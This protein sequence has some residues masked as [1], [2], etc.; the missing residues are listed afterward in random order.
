PTALA[1]GLEGPASLPTSRYVP[2]DWGRLR[3]N[4]VQLHD[5]LPLTPALLALPVVGFVAALMRA[6]ATALLLGGWLAAFVVVKGS[7]TQASIE[8]GTLWRLV[9]PALPPFVLLVA[10]APFA[11]VRRP[12]RIEES[13]ALGRRS[14]AVLAVVFA[15]IPLL[16]FAVLPPLRSRTAIK[17]FPE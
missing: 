13:Q 16:L 14:L 6:R 3:D 10:A 11:F 15:A 17:Y 2:L 12:R 9:M 4:Y 7:S 1:A 5:V 8:S